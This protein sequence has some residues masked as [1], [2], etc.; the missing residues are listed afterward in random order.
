MKYY[1]WFMSPACH[2]T[3]SGP[4]DTHHAAIQYGQENYK[5]FA[6]FNVTYNT[7]GHPHNPGYP[8]P[9]EEEACDD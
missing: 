5:E 9:T 3:I 7:S 4:F 1:V 8:G 2:N 6:I